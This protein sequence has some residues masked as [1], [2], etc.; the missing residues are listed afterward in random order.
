VDL[1]CSVGG[2]LLQVNT[3]KNQ[4]KSTT[5]I[6]GLCPVSILC[7]SQTGCPTKLLPK[8]VQQ[9]FNYDMTQKQLPLI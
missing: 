1:L 6:A 9:F 3:G 7:R 5:F 8:S 2:N 4:N